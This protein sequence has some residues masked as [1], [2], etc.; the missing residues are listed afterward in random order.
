MMAEIRIGCGDLLPAASPA[1]SQDD[2]L[3][4]LTLEGLVEPNCREMGPNIKHS[5]GQLGVR[6]ELSAV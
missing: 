2:I 3:C 5:P 1:V 4:F 6:L